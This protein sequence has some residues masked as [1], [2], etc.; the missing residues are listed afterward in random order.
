MTNGT[1]GL[2]NLSQAA[3]ALGLVGE[4]A[5]VAK[6]KKKTVKDITKLG[7]TNIVGTSLI[8]AQGK[9]ISTL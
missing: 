9:I 3:L 7:I 1:I 8:S 5:R 2:L 4:S 6:K